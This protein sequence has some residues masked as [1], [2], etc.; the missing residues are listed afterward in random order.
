MLWRSA[1][2][3]EQEIKMFLAAVLDILSSEK[4]PK[5]ISSKTERNTTPGTSN[6][7]NVFFEL[8]N[9]DS[10]SVSLYTRVIKDDQAR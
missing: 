2:M 3:S 7:T 10:M 5:M 1:I 9:G 8:R 6:L 4:N